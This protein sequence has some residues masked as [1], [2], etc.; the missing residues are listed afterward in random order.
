ML[1]E[2]IGIINRPDK[3]PRDSDRFVNEKLRPKAPLP[4]VKIK[5]NPD[6]LKLHSRRPARSGFHRRNFHAEIAAC[7]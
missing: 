4:C 1:E 6:G 5:P 2:P 3:E 7:R